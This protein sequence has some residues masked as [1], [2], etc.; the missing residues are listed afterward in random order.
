MTGVEG[1]VGGVTTPMAA[2]S[3][4]AVRDLMTRPGAVGEVAPLVVHLISDDSSYST[5]ADF[6]ADG[7]ETASSRPPLPM[8]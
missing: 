8:E 2:R 6:V 4:T 1:R 5:D 7:G 3:A